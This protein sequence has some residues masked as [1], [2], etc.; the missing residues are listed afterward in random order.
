MSWS[1]KRTGE[2]QPKFK[3]R[4]SSER[5]TT[6]KR[7]YKKIECPGSKVPF[8]EISGGGLKLLHSFV[9]HTS[10]SRAKQLF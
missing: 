2:E 6:I 7:D 5:G 9:L 4:K 1:C 10:K 3:P 8:E